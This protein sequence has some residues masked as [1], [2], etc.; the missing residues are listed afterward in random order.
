MTETAPARE[1]PATHLGRVPALAEHAALLRRVIEPALPDEVETLSLDDALHRTTATAV[2]SPVD[3]PLFRN[4][5]MDGF[6]VLAHD[7]AAAP[8]SL[9][10]AGVIPAAAGEPEALQPGTAV[11]IMTGAVVPEGADAVVPVERVERSEGRV[12]FAATVAPGTFVRDRGSDVRAG[13]TLLPAGLHLQARH[14]GALAAAGVTEVTVRRRPR[15]A[16]LTTG[17]E[18]IDVAAVP[19][20]GEVHDAN[21]VALAAAIVAVGA[22][23]VLRARVIDDVAAFD[24]QLDAALAAADLVIASGGISQGDFEVVR[25][26]LEPRGAWV[27]TVAMQPGGPQS[28]AVLD[29]VPVV[30]FPGNPVSTQLSFEVFVAPLLREHAGMPAAVREVRRLAAAVESPRGRQQLLRARLGDGDA[31]APVSGPGS[32]LVAGLAAADALIDVPAEA[33]ALPAGT[34]VEVVRL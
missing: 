21:A 34:E 24:A 30:G 14:L 12:S 8:V 32:H 4:S 28:V 1:W 10:I 31:V 29:G 33:T 25:E 6:A 5:Q 16:V 11:R 9:P 23:V 15:I 3:L 7:L 20:P 27:G 13:D 17:S 22:E 2:T 19:R 18:L 26:A